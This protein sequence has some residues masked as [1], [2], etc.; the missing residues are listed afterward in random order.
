[1]M[2]NSELGQNEILESEQ[3]TE[4]KTM[5]T[6]VVNKIRNWICDGTLKE[7]QKI[8]LTDIAKRL[9]V[10]EMPVR[11]AIKMLVAQGL[12]ESFPYRGTWVKALS[13]EDIQELY[14]L[15]ELLESQALFFAIA[16]INSKEISELKKLAAEVEAAINNNDML[17]YFEK[18]QIFHFRLYAA[19]RQKQ[20]CS[21]I[22]TV[23]TNLAYYRL[24]YFRARVSQYAAVNE[25]QAYIQACENR[26]YK[27]AQEVLKNALGNH[28]NELLNNQN[29]K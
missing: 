14:M 13:V 6:H 7:G 19:S 11:E 8:G 18:N 23:W 21:L 28:L 17:G 24:I 9:G 26:D 22:S 5:S 16:R 4:I 2:E 25:H 20:L 12:L 29:F 1:M 15:R 27:A 3:L 10:S